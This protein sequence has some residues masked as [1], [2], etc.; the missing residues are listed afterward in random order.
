MWWD[1]IAKFEN[2]LVTSFVKCR[3]S[4]L[5]KQNIIRVFD[6]CAYEFSMLILA[7][8]RHK[9][10]FALKSCWC[11]AA[12]AVDS[13]IGVDGSTKHLGFGYQVGLKPIHNTDHSSACFLKCCCIPSNDKNISKVILA[14]VSYIKWTWINSFHIF[15]VSY[16]CEI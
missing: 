1:F 11:S 2:I 10:I 7:I 5:I 9:S 8:D 12:R 14:S 13:G 15:T 6:D 3:T 16:I 4:I